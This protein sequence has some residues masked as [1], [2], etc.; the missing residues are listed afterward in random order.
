MP[1]G[2]TSY[3]NGTAYD[4]VNG[5]G[6]NFVI[7]VI[8][9]SGTGSKSYN[10]PGFD[11][12]ASIV[13][14][15]TSRGSKQITYN[16]SVSGQTVSWSNIDTTTKLM[17]IATSNTILN[18]EGFLY[19]DRNAN[20]FKLAPTFTPFNLTQV[21]DL[22]PAFDQVV[23]TNVPASLPML[24]FHRST[25]GSGFDHVWWFEV[26]VNGYWALQFRP[27]F[28]V[29]MGPTRI[30]VFSKMMVNVPAGGFYMYNNGQMVW[31]SNCL[32]LQ[33]ISGSTTNAGQPVAITPGVSVILSIPSQ[34]ATPNVGTTRYNCYSAGINTSGNWEASGAD[35]YSSV[36]Y[37]NPSGS[38]LP[39]SVSCGPPAYTF[40]TPYD[41]Y[42]RQ[43]LG[44]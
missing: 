17:V 11:I 4:A 36:F 24:A 18:Y 28:G 13:G 34:P 8:Y 22:T 41:N 38:G 26:N 39:P 16:V 1:D 2:F 29:A 25:A 21:I 44:V 37:S 35:I 14:G 7:D 40:T 33:M 30:Y 5:M 31:H 43:A 6:Y 3:I 20:R 32:P 42:Y 15:R 9:I 23:Q 19:N 27:N 10:A 12:S